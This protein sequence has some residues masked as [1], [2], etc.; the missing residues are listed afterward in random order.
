MDLNEEIK[1]KLKFNYQTLYYPPIKNNIELSHFLI[2]DHF[3]F[4]R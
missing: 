1:D 4:K 2:K 3:L